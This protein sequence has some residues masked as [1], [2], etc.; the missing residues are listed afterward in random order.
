[1]PKGCGSEYKFYSFR[2]GE[3]IMDFHGPG[4]VHTNAEKYFEHVEMD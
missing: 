1:M 2:K 4:S 3:M